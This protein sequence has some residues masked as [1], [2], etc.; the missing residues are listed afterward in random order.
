MLVTET[1]EVL[2]VGQ[3]AN[4]HKAQVK[5]SYVSFISTYPQKICK[6]GIR[7]PEEERGVLAVGGKRALPC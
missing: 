7:P 2:A 3:G 4:C 5:N 1:R 6:S